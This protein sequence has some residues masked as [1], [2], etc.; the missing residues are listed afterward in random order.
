M[1]DRQ[2]D[3]MLV[4]RAQKGEQK[5]FEML[6]SKYQR[7]LIRL[8]SRFVKDEHEVNDVAQ[9]AMIRA[10]RALP[11]FRGESAFYTWL[12]RISINAAKN[13]LATSGKRPFI[14]AEAANEEGDIFDLADQIADYHTPEAEMMNR[15]ILQTVEK[16]ISKLPDDLRKAISLREMEGLSYEEIAQIMR[17]PIGTVRSRIFRA[18][19]VIAKDLRPLLD[20]TENQRW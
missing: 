15:E 19:E 8:I 6:M 10:Y 18:R 16:A 1:N 17:C 12:Y 14:S 11:N 9:E 2:I 3:Q 20:T 7:R 4:E 5:A 13:F